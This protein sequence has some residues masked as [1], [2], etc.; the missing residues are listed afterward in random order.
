MAIT[1]TVILASNETGIASTEL[2]PEPEHW[3]ALL[4]AFTDQRLALPAIWA[5]I[6][7]PLRQRSKD[8][9]MVVGQIGQTIDGRIATV[10]GQ[11]KYI[12]G[13]AGLKHLHRLRALVD[14]VV[15]GVGTANADNPMLT[16]RMVKGNH[17]ARV[18]IDPNARLQADV[19]IFNDDGARRIVITKTGQSYPVPPG[20]E[21]LYLPETDGKIL[22]QDILEGL[23]AL[24]FQR[25]LIEGGAD[26]VSRFIESGC[27]DRLHVI[28]APIIMGS[29]RAA[30]SLPVIE[31]MDEA[32]RLMVRTHLLEDEVLFDCDLSAQRID[33]SG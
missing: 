13:A 24:G 23:S 14:A 6:F 16:V 30:F 19:N 15:V 9:P 17:P 11:S 20:V 12:N 18:I 21:V 25:I 3:Q 27:M 8:K 4:E 29:G 5:E 26:T 1:S 10:T 28:V 33:R 31:H 7:G 32:K 22:P 2:T